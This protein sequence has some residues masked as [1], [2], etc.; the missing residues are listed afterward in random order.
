MEYIDRVVYINLDRRADRR[1]HMT[2]LLSSYEIDAMRFMAIEHDY[3]LYGCGLSHLAALKMAQSEKWNRVLILED[4]IIFNLS[5]EDLQ[6]RLNTL[7]NHGPAFDVCMLDVNLQQSEPAE[8]DWLLRVK[9]AHCAGAY[10]VE[11]HYYQTLI[12]LYEFA[13]PKLLETGAHWIYANDAVWR[14]LQI[15]D[16]WYTFTDKLCR[17]MTGY[18]DTKNMVI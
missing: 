7:F 6:T 11:K 5:K 10:I 15:K 8:Q 17:Q 14:D 18:S 4:D 3:G 16:R 13:M 9:Y 1:D 12:D 2:T